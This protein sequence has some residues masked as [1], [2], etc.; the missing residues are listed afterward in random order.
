MLTST[1]IQAESTTLSEIDVLNLV[2]NIRTSE[3]YKS[4]PAFYVDIKA[5]I[6]ALDGSVEARLINAIITKLEILGSGVVEINQEQTVGT[7]GLIYSQ[8]SEREAFIDY[9]VNIMYE[10]SYSTV[11]V[12]DDS[13][14][15]LHGAYAVGRLPLDYEGYL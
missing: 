11:E 2:S 5:K 14:M 13:V 12:P 10:E 8:K 7:D 6:E 1:E 3:R 9:A 4:N 15:S